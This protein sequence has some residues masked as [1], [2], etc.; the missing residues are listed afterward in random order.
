MSSPDPISST[1]PS[2]TPTASTS[3]AS[4]A[5]N[6]TAPATSVADLVSTN[7]TFSSMAGLKGVAPEVAKAMEMGIA[8][9]I[10]YEM[11]KG[12]KR[13]KN[14]IETGDPQG[15]APPLNDG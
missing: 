15:N 11:Q 3:S 1:E 10:I 8:M 7:V 12:S 13:L 2:I 4:S 6:K 14:I 9:N 5:T